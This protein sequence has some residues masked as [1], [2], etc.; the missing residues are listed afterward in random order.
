MGM[1]FIKQFFLVGKIDRKLE[2]SEIVPRTIIGSCDE[3]ILQS[4]DVGIFLTI[5]ID[6][7]RIAG[8]RLTRI[9]SRQSVREGTSIPEVISPARC[10]TIDSDYPCTEGE[11]LCAKHRDVECGSN[12]LHRHEEL[13]TSKSEYIR[14]L[15]PDG[16]TRSIDR[17][18]ERIDKQSTARREGISFGI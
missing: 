5:R 9:M 17:P 1:F 14:T 3:S 2:F 10:S 8:N 16:I 11:I 7:F 6:I 12:G 15:V 18:F 4:V 13:S